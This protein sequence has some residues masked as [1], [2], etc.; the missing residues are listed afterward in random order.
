VLTS[1]SSTGVVYTAECCLDHPERGAEL[2]EDMGKRGACHL[3]EAI[4]RGG[5]LDT[6][7]QSLNENGN[8]ELSRNRL[9]EYGQKGARNPRSNILKKASLDFLNE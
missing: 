5:C 8:D 9:S 3:L 4:R 2:S 6:S 1:E 7:C